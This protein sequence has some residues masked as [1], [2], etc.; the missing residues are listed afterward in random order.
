MFP[1][2]TSPAELREAKELLAACRGEL[3]AEQVPCGE[4]ELGAMIETPAA[5]MLSDLLAREV[6]FFSIGTNDLTQYTLAADRASTNIGHLY[7]PG[8]PAVLRMMRIAVQNAAKNGIWCGIC[9]ESAS[10]RRLTEIYLEM[11]ITKFSVAPSEILE[12]R[13]KI[14]SIDLTRRKDKAPSRI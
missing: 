8:H 2:I 1:M 4:I 6:D 14:Q 10:D 7:D 13:E 11:G 5:V 9:G 3:D 12:L